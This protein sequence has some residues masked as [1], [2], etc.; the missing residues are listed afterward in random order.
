MRKI[1][2]A[3]RRLAA[4]AVDLFSIFLIGFLI[5][6]GAGA[7]LGFAYSL[8]GDGLPFPNWHGQSLGKKIFRIKAVHF[9]SGDSCTLRQSVLRNSPIALV[10]FFAIFPF[11]GW[12]LA[13][14]VGIPL[15][16]IESFLL[17]RANRGQRL[18]DVMADTEVIDLR[19]D[20]T[21]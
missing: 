17:F 2:P 6:R 16:G 11:W 10:T 19:Q 21:Q 1:A 12:I 15:M 9:Q 4:K 3:Q 7:L 13:F 8:V 14:L 20:M 18:G 5:P